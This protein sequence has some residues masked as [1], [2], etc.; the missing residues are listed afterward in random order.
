[1][2]KWNQKWKI[3]HTVLERRTL[4]FSSCKNREL[5]VKLWWVGARDRKKGAFF[6]M[7]IFSKGN[8][9][10]IFVLSQCIM[11]W[12]NFQNICTFTFQKTLLHTLFC[13]FL[14]SSKA[15]SVSINFT[16]NHKITFCQ[17]EINEGRFSEIL[18][19]NPICFHIWSSSCIARFIYYKR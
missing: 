1:M 17:H 3:S 2:T 14:K 10:V 19:F 8:F 13:L 6:V 16:K 12:V 7:F 4:C 18:K 5:K 11:Y 15:F 9:I